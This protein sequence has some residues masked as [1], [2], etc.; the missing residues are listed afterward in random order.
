MS[1][2]V[3]GFGVCWCGVKTLELFEIH[4]LR[5]FIWKKTN[6]IFHT[7]SYKEPLCQKK[8][9]TTKIVSLCVVL[10]SKLTNVESCESE[11]CWWC[12]THKLK[13]IQNCLC[14]TVIFNISYNTWCFSVALLDVTK[15]KSWA[16]QAGK[17]QP[18]RFK[19]YSCCCREYNAA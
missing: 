1:H 14:K 15:M 16:A 4:L 9:S 7:T 10:T 18:A 6:N 2:Y 8:R 13:S 12:I 3:Y 11:W 19:D 17:L 5:S